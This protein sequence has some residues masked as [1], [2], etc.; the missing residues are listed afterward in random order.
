M[1]IRL[2]SCVAFPCLLVLTG[3]G[4]SALFSS[5]RYRIVKTPV[6]SL[7][8]PPLRDV[9]Q[10]G[11]RYVVEIS[12]NAKLAPPA[13][14]GEACTLK[15]PPFELD[16][17]RKGWK[18]T[19]PLINSWPPPQVHSD[20][21]LSA[22]AFDDFS[23]LVDRS[24]VTPQQAPKLQRAVRE[25][26]PSTPGDSAR[27][28]TG[29]RLDEGSI[30]LQPGMRLKMET[31]LFRNNSTS[32]SDYIGT[33]VSITKVIAGP[34]NNTVFQA[35]PS[36]AASLAAEE[37]TALLQAARF[38]YYRLF[39]LTL[40]VQ[41]DV[42][43]AALIVGSNDIQAL[44]QV[45]GQVREQPSSPCE[46]LATIQP[47]MFCKAYPPSTSV[48]VEVSVSLNGESRYIPAGS[49]IRSIF[50]PIKPPDL[51]TFLGQLRI[52]RMYA[53]TDFPVDFSA[54]PPAVM[55]LTLVNADR[56]EWG[57]ETASLKPL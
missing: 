48:S 4:G 27:Y 21:R 16:A 15:Q 23:V 6:A 36:S 20:T 41:S 19:M 47:S 34:D 7:V 42:E 5:K 55:D 39:L 3:C 38:R 31:A 13:K 50:T 46:H 52:F 2:Y 45:L 37:Q 10:S 25:S 51:D 24:C 11:A 32:L 30:D 35:E 18:L 14:S 54:D 43:R 56:V 17:D 26:L 33:R 12:R 28:L 8:L 49:S 40:Y 53:G 29:M 22:N 9:K 44:A 57:P 1:S